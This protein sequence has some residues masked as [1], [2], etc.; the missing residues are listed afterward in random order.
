VEFLHDVA[1]AQKPGFVDIFP[2]EAMCD[3]KTIMYVSLTGAATS[4]MIMREL[5]ATPPTVCGWLTA[6]YSGRRQDGAFVSKLSTRAATDRTFGGVGTQL[7]R[8]VEGIGADF[9]YLYPV[10]SAIGF[11]EKA[12]Y[13]QMVSGVKHMFKIVAK[14]KRVHLP[15]LQSFASSLDEVG[16]FMKEAAKILDDDDYV[17]LSTKIAKD[18]EEAY[19]AMAIF[20]EDPESLRKWLDG[21]V[22]GGRPKAP[23]GRYHN[24]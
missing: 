7:L 18:P 8:A 9:I 24:R 12:G 10:D 4:N 15:R 22:K 23:A 14:D 21:G 1:V 17:R 19:T 6:T 16:Q 2:W 3:E 5:R 13:T 20:E 11:Y